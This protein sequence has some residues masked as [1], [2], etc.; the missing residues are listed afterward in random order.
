MTEIKRRT[1]LPSA[2]IEIPEE[3]ETGK[4][5]SCPARKTRGNH[6]EDSHQRTPAGWGA[7]SE[8]EGVCGRDAQGDAV[9]EEVE[10]RG[11]RALRAV[12]GRKTKRKYFK[13]RTGPGFC[14]REK[15][16]ERTEGTDNGKE[17]H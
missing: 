2:C 16:E 10:E 11:R 7:L 14:G 17:N 6:E 3:I 5:I 8:D 4:A 1:R 15:R 9:A 12:N 13:R